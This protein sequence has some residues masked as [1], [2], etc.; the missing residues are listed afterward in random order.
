MENLIFIFMQRT[1]K[2]WTEIL[3]N[4]LFSRNFLS[5]ERASE[6]SIQSN[7]KPPFIT[8]KGHTK[9]NITQNA[10]NCALC[11][12]GSIF[13]IYFAKSFVFWPSKDNQGLLSYQS[14]QTLTPKNYMLTWLPCAS[15]IFR[16]SPRYVFHPYL[17]QNDHQS[18]YY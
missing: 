10:H 13:Y 5:N 16:I 11:A 9:T 12:C 8:K 2:V 6:L 17:S 4:M 1:F 7:K 3:L 14:K 18:Q 15:N